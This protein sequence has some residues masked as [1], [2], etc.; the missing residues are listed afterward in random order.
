MVLQGTAASCDHRTVPE[1]NRVAHL[2]NAQGPSGATSE[3]SGRTD[4]ANMYAL[5]RHVKVLRARIPG[6]QALTLGLLAS[7]ECIYRTFNSLNEIRRLGS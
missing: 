1:P 2:L 5:R 4:P 7:K 3:T 6:G